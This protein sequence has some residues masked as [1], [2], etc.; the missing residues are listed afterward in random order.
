MRSC[1]TLHRD[2]AYAAQLVVEFQNE[3]ERTESNDN[4]SPAK[5]HIT[6]LAA[7]KRQ[8]R[9]AIR[10]YFAGEDELAIHSVASAA[11]RL[12]ADLKAE[13][14]MEEAADVYLASIFYV[15]R[16]Y[17][18]ESL[19]KDMTSNPEF[20]DWVRKFA[21]QLPIEKDTKIEHVSLTLSPTAVREFWN[22]RNKVANF[23]KHADRDAGSSIVLD[24]VD[25]LLLLMQCYIAYQDLTP[26]ELGNEGLV[27]QLFLGSTKKERSAPTSRQDELIEKMA[28]VP[29][30]DRLHLCSAFI[31]ELNEKEH[32]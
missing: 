18:R 1:G 15:V 24:E 13:R 3:L 23:L 2:A 27:F 9:A 30:A 7:A 28:D 25:N 19:P 29:E 17:R 4:M 14:G 5:L 26:E 22:T 10:M 6:K 8:L 21:D 12:L 20:M 31:T 11:Y 16:D 32:K